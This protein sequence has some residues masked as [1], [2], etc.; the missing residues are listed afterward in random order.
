MKK[1]GILYP[2]SSIISISAF[3]VLIF[4]NFVSFKSVLYS[5]YISYA[6]AGVIIL[7]V[8]RKYIKFEFDK[9]QAYK[10]FNYGIY[11]VISG[12]SAVIYANIGKIFINIYMTTADVGIYTAYNYSFVMMF[13]IFG[14]VITTVLFPVAS[15]YK[16]KTVIVKRINKTVPFIVILG[17]I[18][19]ICL[20]SII[21]MFYG[22]E[23]GFHLRLVLL[24]G[25]VGVIMFFD[26]IY[27]WLMN[28]V[29]KKGIRISSFAALI[30][31]FSNTILNIFLIPLIGLEGAVIA[32]IISYLLSLIIL[33]S[34]RKYLYNSS[35]N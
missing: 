33:L 3:L 24:F 26:T 11:A 6:V 35:D 25:I 5:Y 31:A 30:M 7:I 27:V 9:A 34:K 32:I 10:L 2:M 22:K 19:S 29:G 23:Y 8:I 17:Y 4:F 1:Y 14:A 18:I 12:I 21:L 20:G 13:T 16:N 15:K 28:S